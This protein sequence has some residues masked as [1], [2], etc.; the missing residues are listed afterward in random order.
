MNKL[1]M[2]GAV[3]I[4][5]LSAI[6]LAS[7]SVFKTT[8][9]NKK[10]E[11]TTVVTGDYVVSFYVN[12]SLY[13]QV[14]VNSGESC[15]LPEVPEVEGYEVAWE[16][17]DLSN[18]TSNIVVNAVLT[19]K[20]YTITYKLT[21]ASGNTM[22]YATESYKYKDT[23]TAPNV[24]VEDGYIFSGWNN[25]PS[26]MT[27]GDLEVTGR[28]LE[29]SDAYNISNY[30]SGSTISITESGTYQ[31]T[32]ENTNV[33]ISVSSTDVTLVLNNVVDLNVVGAMISSSEA[34]T[35][36]IAGNNTISNT[37]DSTEGG[38][39][40][41]SAAL[42][43]IGDGCLNITNNLQSAAAIYTYKSE[44][45][46]NGG[47]YILSSSGIGLQAKGKGGNINITGGNITA[48]TADSSIKAK[49]SVEVSGGTIN[50]TSTAGD[51]INADT[52]D[53]SNGSVTIISKQDGIQGDSDVTISGGTIDITA[54]G[55]KNGNASLTTTSS[56]EFE[57]TDTS[58][59]TTADE[60]Y[61]LYVYVSN[62]YVEITE[63]N[64]NTYSNYSQFYDMAGCKGIKSDLLV[65]ISGGTINIDSLD[66]GIKSKENVVISGGNTTITSQCDGIQADTALNVSGGVID[67]TTIGTFY[68]VSG[69]SYK[70]SGTSYVRADSGSYDLYNSNKGLKS[71]TDII[72]S[73]GTITTNTADDAIHSDTYVTITGGTFNLTTLDDGVH[74]DTTVDIGVLG[75]A[76]GLIDLNVLSAFEGIEAGTVNINSG[77]ISVYGLDDGINAG[78]G[79]DNTSTN[80]PFTPGGG[81]SSFGPTQQ[82][83]SSSNYS[84]NINGGVVVVKVASGDTDAIDSNGTYS[85]TGGVVISI[86]A[87][88][89]GTAT[90]LDT[91]GSA[92]ITGGIFVGFGKLETTPSTS[93]VTKKSVTTKLSAGEYTLY[94]SSS[95]ALAS[96][97]L[98]AA[99]SSYTFIASSGT[100]TISGSS[101]SVTITC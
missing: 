32:G 20:T 46:I 87:S 63:E 82:T 26:T 36:S 71:D 43:M 35:V 11:T 73:G 68:S 88:S 64:Y 21:D 30:A 14:G 81:H 93:G 33:L 29:V 34:L 1:K 70:K 28:I 39:I 57:L 41:S 24:D 95:Q 10:D 92:S 50:I 18:I 52:V 2:L 47:T 66:D 45:N 96:F 67:I 51:G 86:N 97:N 3:S 42:T 65:T 98:P 85:Q 23:I 69:G 17:V 7:C 54:N 55:G 8:E 22:V 38:V 15:S 91:D 89:S 16:E 74:A 12:G 84:I 99:Y 100:Y 80:D 31:I 77:T 25:L 76:N 5:A 6:S 58:A 83:T 78:G 19:K 53:V 44:L 49:G 62:R 48:T 40:S 60:Y 101:S 94:N 75:A 72:I 9:D 61:G 4:A 90:S 13:K 56:F 79:S 37:S 59:F 27:A